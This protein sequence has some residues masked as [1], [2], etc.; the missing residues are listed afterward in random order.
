MGIRERIEVINETMN[1]KVL[2]GVYS[3]F[4]GGSNKIYAIYEYTEEENDR[5]KETENSDISDSDISEMI[6][7]ISNFDT[8]WQHKFV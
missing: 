5:N 2:K 3:R 1:L 6:S 7:Y 4:L 8:D